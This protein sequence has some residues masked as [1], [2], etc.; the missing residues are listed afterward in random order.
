MSRNEN[1]IMDLWQA[2]LHGT[3][4]LREATTT[5]ELKAI[6]D[7]LAERE[8]LKETIEHQSVRQPLTRATAARLLPLLT[9][10]ESLEGEIVA[11]MTHQYHEEKSAQSRLKGYGSL[12]DS[13]QRFVDL[14][15]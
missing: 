14:A 15:T 11:A 3:M 4:A 10:I 9:Q 7:L 5:G 13:R 12:T 8:L 1:R 2:Y 6:L